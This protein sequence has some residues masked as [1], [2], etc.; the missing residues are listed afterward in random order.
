[1]LRT[2]TSHAPFECDAAPVNEETPIVP[3]LRPTGGVAEQTCLHSECDRLAHGFSGEQ[4]G[5]PTTVREAS[6]RLL[7]GGLRPE[8]RVSLVRGDNGLLK[9][10]IGQ[11]NATFIARRPFRAQRTDILQNDGHVEVSGEGHPTANVRG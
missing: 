4:P 11:T 3:E 9:G 10:A 6:P 8:N 1:M 2:C 7:R 5:E